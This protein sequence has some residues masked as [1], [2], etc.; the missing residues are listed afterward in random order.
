MLTLQMSAAT[1][2]L[3]VD[4]VTQNSRLMLANLLTEAS[5]QALS[6]RLSD[7]AML[8]HRRMICWFSP[9]CSSFLT[10]NYIYSLMHTEGLLTV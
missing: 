10:W 7:S 8:L 3:H 1:V 6:V 4:A 5:F 2:S 9:V